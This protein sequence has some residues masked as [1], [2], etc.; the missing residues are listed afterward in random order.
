ME[1]RTY[2][3][4]DIEKKEEEVVQALLLE[5]TL[6]GSSLDVYYAKAEMLLMDI[7]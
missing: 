2:I 5:G 3:N 6:N 1:K 7:K 4:K